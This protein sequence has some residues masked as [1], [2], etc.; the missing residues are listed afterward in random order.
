[1][2]EIVSNGSYLERFFSSIENMFG[3]Y[4]DKLE[5]KAFLDGSHVK[6]WWKCSKGHEWEV[7]IKERTKINGNHC[8]IC[9]K[10]L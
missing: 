1:M 3:N 5:R 6:V 9:Q 8:P 2:G 4:R 10:K 7:V